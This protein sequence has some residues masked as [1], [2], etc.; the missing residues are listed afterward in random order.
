MAR[1][2]LTLCQYIYCPHKA[3]PDVQK[4]AK[5]IIGTDYPFPIL[6]EHA[7][8]DR[9]IAR[10]KNAFALGLHG[11]SKEVLDGSAEGMLR[12]KHEESGVSA[13]GEAEVK[14][15]KQIKDEKGKRKR[16]KEGNQSLDGHFKKRVK[17][18]E[19]KSGERGDVHRDE[20]GKGEVKETVQG[21]GEMG[22]REEKAD[23]KLK[24]GAK[25][26]GKGNGKGK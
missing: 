16:E 6:D 21:D 17:E 3:P 9:C 22:K 1:V 10:L 8:K 4:K 15:E 25:G 18:E 23:R 2:A 5:C 19:G 13:G 20:E 7:E 24:E 14:S 26:K 12:A 11:D